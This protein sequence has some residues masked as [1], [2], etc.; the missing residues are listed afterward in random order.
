MFSRNASADI[1]LYIV[2]FIQKKVYATFHQNSGNDLTWTL[3]FRGC[4]V[5]RQLRM[6]PAV[7]Q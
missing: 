6:A 1:Q 4:I 2:T 3:C 5:L 7:K